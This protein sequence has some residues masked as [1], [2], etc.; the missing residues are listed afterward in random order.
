[1]TG[2]LAGSLLANVWCGLL[3]LP[4]RR[5]LPVR[6]TRRS[7]VEQMTLGIDVACRAAHQASLADE[8]GRFAWIGPPVPHHGR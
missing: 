5:A 7:I 8:A 2:S 3:A 6:L 1:M 4:A